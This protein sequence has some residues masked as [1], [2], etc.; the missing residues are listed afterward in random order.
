MKNYK[1]KKQSPYKIYKSTG[2]LNVQVPRITEYTVVQDSTIVTH[3][4]DYLPNREGMANMIC[5]LLNENK[6][7]KL[8]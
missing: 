1:V 2:G 7:Y 8:T 5:K 6:K 4:P 3:I